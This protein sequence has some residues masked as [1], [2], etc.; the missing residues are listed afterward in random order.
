[1]AKCC[2][3]GRKIGGFGEDK[4]KITDE[5]VA[6]YKCAP[7]FRKI[8]NSETTEQLEMSENELRIEIESKN[9]SQEIIDVVENEIQRIKDSKQFMYQQEQFQM[10]KEEEIRKKR[11]AFMI[12]TGYNF[13]GY[14]IQKYIDLAHG[15]IVLG[16]GF[17]SELSASIS[18][19]LGTSSKTFEGKLS[20]AK[21]AAQEQMIINAMTLNANALIG[22][23]F[24]ITTFSNN[25][26]AVSANGTAVVIEKIEK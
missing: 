18:D 19:L 12:S 11:K 10:Q 7:F 24:D 1:M 16:T 21:R 17:Y 9:V 13:E 15:E 8:I 25:I 23:D 6:C 5:Y 14:K 20:Q 4:Y 26:I 2:I 22:V 3:C